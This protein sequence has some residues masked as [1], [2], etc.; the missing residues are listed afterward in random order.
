MT[1]AQERI[2]SYAA[3]YSSAYGFESEQVKARQRLIGEMVARLQP[4]SVVELGCGDELLL[5]SCNSA[6][7]TVETWIVVEPA[8][9]FANRAQQL[10][11]GDTRVT[12]LN[13]FAEDSTGK[14]RQAIPD[15]ADLVIASSVL[16]EVPDPR[17]FLE[18]A[19]LMCQPRG[20][21]HVNVPNAF[22]LH[23]RLARAMGIIDNEFAFSDRNI[24][25]GQFRVYD[26]ELLR[27]DVLLAD[28][29][30]VEEGGYFMKPF[31]H[32][33]MERVISALGNDVLEGLWVLG[34]EFPSLASEIYV[35]CTL[36]PQE[37][38]H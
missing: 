26:S 36:R 29:D 34:R 17:Q 3:A 5:K 24:Q 8:D 33:Q 18:A 14:V 15:G 22:S 4:K 38:S 35:N 32:Q 30:V 12:V 27:S 16:H 20:I 10:L 2:D 25:L 19:K 21:I 1:M 11:R 7:S 23:R 31:T 28:L 9:R 13:A 6:A 37:A